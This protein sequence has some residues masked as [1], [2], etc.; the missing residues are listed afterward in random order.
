MIHRHSLAFYACLITLLAFAL[1]ILGK[2]HCKFVFCFRFQLTAILLI[3]FCCSYLNYIFVCCKLGQSS[4]TYI[5]VLS[6]SYVKSNSSDSGIALFTYSPSKLQFNGTAN[7]TVRELSCSV[8]HNVMDAVS[9]RIHNTN[10]SA[11]VFNFTYV[12][13]ICFPCFTLLVSQARLAEKR[14]FLLSSQLATD[15]QG[16]KLFIGIASQTYP[17]AAIGGSITARTLHTFC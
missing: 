4:S 3:A 17:T 6:G 13:H 11:I 14:V 2:C 12:G 9:I 5:A 16:G 10:T 1:C 8:Q 7:I 15:L